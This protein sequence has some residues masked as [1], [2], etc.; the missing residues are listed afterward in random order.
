[1]PEVDIL[2]PELVKGSEKNTV[3]AR[4]STSFFVFD[5]SGQDSSSS[6]LSPRTALIAIIIETEQAIIT[7]DRWNLLER[8]SRRVY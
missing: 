5:V 6:Y 4:P 8:S 7:G 2:M 1:M 3:L